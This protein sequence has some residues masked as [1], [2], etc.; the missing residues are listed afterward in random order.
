[1]NGE[2]LREKKGG[3]EG[4]RQSRAKNRRPE[5][6]FLWRLWVEYETRQV[7]KLLL[8]TTRNNLS[9]QTHPLRLPF[10]LLLP[11]RGSR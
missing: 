9:Q 3:K 2:A 5:D 11:L 8:E 7:K 4:A 10:P 1:M 6:P